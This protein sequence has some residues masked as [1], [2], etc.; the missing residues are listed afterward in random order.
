GNRRPG[1]EFTDLPKTCALCLGAGWSDSFAPTGARFS[2][3]PG[4]QRQAE[5]TF[6]YGGG[7]D[8]PVVKLLVLRAE[9]RGLVYNSPD[10]NIHSLNDHALTHTA[11][12]SAG[13]VFRF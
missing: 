1:C 5:A 2:D 6:V 8:F 7:V 9:Y 12:P 11:E 4:A 3:V 10:F 13:G